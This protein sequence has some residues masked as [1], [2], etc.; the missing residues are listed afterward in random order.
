MESDVKG[1]TFGDTETR[2][3]LKKILC[4]TPLVTGW[5][6]KKATLLVTQKV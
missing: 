5:V 4:E 3:S 2:N 1:D 6:K